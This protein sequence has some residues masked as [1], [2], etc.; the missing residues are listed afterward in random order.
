[1]CKKLLRSMRVGIEDWRKFNNKIQLKTLFSWT[2]QKNVR[3][4]LASDTRTILVWTEAHSF[5]F[6]FLKAPLK[7][8]VLGDQERPGK[9][10]YFAS[11]ERWATFKIFKKELYFGQSFA[12]K[13]TLF[14]CCIFLFI[15][16]RSFFWRRFN[17]LNQSLWFF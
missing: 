12:F 1:M 17:K 4:F 8:W 14:S 15:Y 3:D 2:S 9:I 5:I 6:A 13:F 7:A 10:K 16:K 11:D